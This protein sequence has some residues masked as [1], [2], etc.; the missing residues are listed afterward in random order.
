[1]RIC[2]LLLEIE[3]LQLAQVLLLGLPNTIDDILN[4]QNKV[5]LTV[6]GISEG[7]VGWV[8]LRDRGEC[9]MRW[10]SLDEHHIARYQAGSIGTTSCICSAP[11]NN[12]SI[13]VCWITK[14][15]VELHRE[16]VEMVDVQWAEVV[17][18]G[19]VQ[20]GIIDGEVDGSWAHFG[21]CRSVLSS[22]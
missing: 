21:G 9:Q 8:C 18:K 19:I 20:E 2:D 16:P 22:R 3:L 11:E 1:M 4:V 5:G 10:P 13:I 15:L 17:V 14:D 6:A 12:R 7:H